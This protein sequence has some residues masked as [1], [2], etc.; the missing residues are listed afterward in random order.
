MLF[1]IRK[2]TINDKEKVKNIAKITWNST[3]EG[4]IPLKI[5][6]KFL[7]ENYSNESIKMRIERSV[8]Y[9]ADTEGEVVGFANFSN[10]NNDGIVEL[11]AIYVYPDYQGNGIG[12]AFLNY[13]L[14]NIPNLKKVYINV[15]KDNKICTDFYN[16]KGFVA[17]E[18]FESKL[19]GN[20]SK[21]IRMRLNK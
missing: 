6:N 15:E 16:S 12:S 11:A 20:T 2:A 19:E 8:L 4:I 17:I 13:A 21:M 9:V 18:E 5:Q 7:Q 14:E 3:Y 1:T 10:A